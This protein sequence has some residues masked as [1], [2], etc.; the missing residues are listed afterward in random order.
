MSE[1]P[2]KPQWLLWAAYVV[3]GIAMTYLGGLVFMLLG[4]L[5]G[6]VL[7]TSAN[8]ADKIT[9][10]AMGPKAGHAGWRSLVYFWVAWLFIVAGNSHFSYRWLPQ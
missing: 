1:G 5:F 6:S 7:G 2:L 8:W 10:S 9:Q 3:S 4:I